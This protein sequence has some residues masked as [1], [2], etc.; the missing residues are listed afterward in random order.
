MHQ[1]MTHIT[2]WFQGNN[3]INLNNP[4]TNLVKGCL[5]NIWNFNTFIRVLILD[6][7]EVFGIVK[8]HFAQ[9]EQEIKLS[10][11]D[12]RLYRFPLCLPDLFMSSCLVN[13]SLV[14]LAVLLLKR[15]LI[16]FDTHVCISKT[17]KIL[18]CLGFDV[19]CH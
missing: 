4:F 5:N 17:I 16:M 7:C 9:V 6:S 1:Q 2:L 19:N 13:Q 18:K 10:P 8:V 12:T 15:K 11:A 3:Y 14:S